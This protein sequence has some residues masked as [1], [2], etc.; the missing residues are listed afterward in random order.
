MP[1]CTLLA[2]LAAVFSVNTGLTPK[3]DATCTY[4]ERIL[5][6]IIQI[7]QTNNCTF[8]VSGYLNNTIYRNLYSFSN[9][10][11]ELVCYN[12]QYRP[13]FTNE[14]N[15]SFPYF[16]VL[17]VKKCGLLW[18]DLD[19]FGKL[20]YLFHLYLEDWKDRWNGEIVETEYWK[21][22]LDLSGENEFGITNSQKGPVVIPQGLRDIEHLIIV[23]ID[24]IPGILGVFSWPQIHELV[25]TN[26]HLS[27]QFTQIHLQTIFPR[28]KHLIITNCNLPQISI[29]SH[30]YVP[31]RNVFLHKFIETFNENRITDLSNCTLNGSI[32]HFHWTNKSLSR[33]NANLFV[34]IQGLKYIDLNSNNLRSIPQQLFRNQARLTH[35]FLAKNL[36]EDI[37]EEL[38]Q[39]LSSLQIV[40]LSDNSLTNISSQLFQSLPSLKNID[41]SGN[42]IAG[43]P[44]GLFN[45]L[46][47]LKK[48][49]LSGNML[50]VMNSRMFR[51]LPALEEINLA[52]NQL[53][54]IADNAISAKLHSLKLIDLS[55]NKL[56]F[57]HL[58]SFSTSY[59]WQIWVEIV[60]P[61]SLSKNLL[62]IPV[63][64]NLREYTSNI[65]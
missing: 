46:K 55:K 29:H 24:R 34:N 60:S 7:P 14:Q 13:I 50:T 32:E 10:W 43:I 4:R 6:C 52:A 41:L 17:H 23:N 30:Y 11:L 31:F 21:R 40:D 25:L 1:V 22:H 8:D 56:P 2:F 38:F 12:T 44:E 18:Q 9:L 62:R 51:K 20:L 53:N 5:E 3:C 64:N 57:P 15:S 47:S 27:S 63:K 65:W 42:S 45:N 16:V 33:V 48:V 19:S 58:Y 61:L 54:Y 35:V 37:P 28:L 36:L 39:S 59:K 26:V 49:Y